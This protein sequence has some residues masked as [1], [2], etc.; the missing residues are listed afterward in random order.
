MAKVVQPLSKEIL[1]V[2]ALLLLTG[3]CRCR[4]S[5]IR[6]LR[7]LSPALAHGLPAAVEAPILGAFCWWCRVHSQVR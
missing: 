7:L 5:V 1:R 2:E 6:E 4:G 3:R